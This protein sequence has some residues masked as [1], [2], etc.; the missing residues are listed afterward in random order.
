MT[1]NNTPLL[2]QNGDLTLP[3][4]PLTT[5]TT[6][7]ALSGSS[8]TNFHI[9]DILV[10]LVMG[11][12][13]EHGT[14]R[15]VKGRFYAGSRLLQPVTNWS[16]IPIDM[17]N[18]VVASFAS[19]PLA[20]IMRY[21][22]PPS[23]VRPL[24]R[25]ITEIL[26]GA[27]VVI[28]CFGMQLRVL[29]L[30]SCVAYVILL[31]CRH[32]RLVTPI[33]VTTWSL[34]YLMLIHQCRLY[35]DYEGYTLDI[36][37]AVM[38]QTQ[39]L[40]SLAFNLYDGVR[41]AK[42]LVSD[43]TYKT[44]DDNAH[45]DGKNDPKRAIVEEGGPTLM[46]SSRECAVAKIPGPIEFA[47]Y[48]MYFHGVCIGPFVF[49][50]D[51]QN[52]LHGYENKHLP[53][54]PFRRLCYLTLRLAVYG[55]T[56]AVLFN[57]IPVNFINHGD[58]QE[59]SLLGQTSY[60]FAAFMVARLKYYFGWCLAEML[61]ICAGNG[62]TG[63]DPETR[64]TLWANVHN[65]DF[66]Q[67]ETAPNLKVLIDAWNIGTVRWLREVV[68]F[69]APLRFRTILVFL[70]SAFWHGLYPGYYLMFTTF[71][72]FTYTSRTWRRNVRPLVLRAESPSLQ[73]FYDFF[74]LLITHFTMEYAQAPF[75]LLGFLPS[76]SLWTRFLFVP[77]IIGVIVIVAVART[78]RYFK[79]V[80]EARVSRR[81]LSTTSHI[82]VYA[83]G[84]VDH[85][86]DCVTI[87]DCNY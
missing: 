17:I 44:L 32:D 67:V 18:F 84:V 85:R 51:Y 22:L 76:I 33:A 14:G 59:L 6:T 10:G 71:A 61:G 41:I 58:F 64:T 54:I 12:T 81:Q 72:L 26:L 42:A 2:P 39:R 69:R 11:V 45:V 23:R 53:P 34:L 27:G 68:Y 63:V 15:S 65:F 56:Y 60:M 47:A 66:F 82:G 70:V 55:L 29:L 79:A 40:S 31:C 83:V 4:S 16:G 78:V 24:F 48:C 80:V 75:H 37:G 28:F 73:C 35:Y 77:H 9:F 57:R 38:L 13:I 74:T 52:Y 50:K 36:S 43:A 19:L 25:A 87:H 8:H 3:S 7:A 20:L 49:F 5:I 62:Y 30:Q 1:V 86:A 46:P 21:G